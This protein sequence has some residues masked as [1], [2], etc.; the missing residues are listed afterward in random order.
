[1]TIM[2]FIE[3]IGY[4]IAVFQTGYALRGLVESLKSKK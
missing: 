4:S 1:M 3:L 2:D